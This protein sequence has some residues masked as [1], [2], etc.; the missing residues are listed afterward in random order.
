MACIRCQLKVAE[1]AQWGLKIDALDAYKK[2]KDSGDKESNEVEMAAGKGELL[3]GLRLQSSERV[4]LNC[5][6]ELENPPSINLT[7]RV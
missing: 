6:M 4:V 7:N 2:V 1:G 5:Q 3:V